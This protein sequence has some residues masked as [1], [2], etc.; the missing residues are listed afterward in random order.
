MNIDKTSGRPAGWGGRT[1]E[2]GT[3]KM[4]DGQG[5]GT[6]AGPVEGMRQ[7]CREEQRWDQDGWTDR[8]AD[9]GEQKVEA[10]ALLQT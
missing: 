8:E 1:R 10:K 3:G 5:W 6:G 9:D 4:G 7:R 2:G